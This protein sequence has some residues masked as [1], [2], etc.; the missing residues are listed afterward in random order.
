MKANTTGKLWHVLLSLLHLHSLLLIDGISYVDFA[1]VQSSEL[2]ILSDVQDA[3]KTS[4]GSAGQ[5]S[6]APWSHLQVFVGFQSISIIQGK[7]RLRRKK[8]VLLFFFF[9]K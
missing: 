6:H 8:N 2:F 3:W 1:V 7:K 9:S 5:T 4:P